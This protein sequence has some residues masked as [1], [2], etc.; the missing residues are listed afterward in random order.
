[1]GFLLCSSLLLLQAGQ[2]GGAVTGPGHLT[3]GRLL[4]QVAPHPG[5]VL[6]SVT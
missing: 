2:R 1:M 5:V 3:P 6:K 4:H